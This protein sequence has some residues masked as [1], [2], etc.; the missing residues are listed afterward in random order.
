MTIAK[1]SLNFILK[2]KQPEGNEH[3]TTAGSKSY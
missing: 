3:G 2:E 1:I